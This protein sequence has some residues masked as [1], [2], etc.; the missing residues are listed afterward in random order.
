[1]MTNDER[2]HKDAWTEPGAFEVHS[3]VYRIPLPL[4]NDGLRAVNVYAIAS[5]DSLVL[6]DSG[7][8]LTESRQALESALQILGAELGDVDRFLITH[9]HQDH[10]SQAVALRE[11]FGSPVHIGRGEEPGL[12]AA[13]TPGYLPLTAQ[14][15]LLRACDAEDVV[16]R[17]VEVLRTHNRR[18]N[19][20]M[21]DAW[22]DDNQVID[23]P[24]RTLEVVHTPGHT[25]GHVV[26]RDS[27]H[28][29]LFAGDHIL[30]HI[31]PS[32]GLEPY[33]EEQP[34]SSYLGALRRVRYMPDTMLLP[35]HG[36][37]SPS[38]HVRSDEILVHHD[39]RLSVVMDAVINGMNTASAVSR[40]MTWTR[41]ELEFHDLD[42]MNQML[43]VLEIGA[44]LDL[45]VHQGRLRKRE[46]DGVQLYERVA[47]NTPAKL[48]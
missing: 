37:I 2:R 15:A 36:P 29:L 47:D 25:R 24:S 17:L 21:P 18:L 3:G 44:H 9:L 27:Q 12:T 32:I 43:A 41:R 7:W 14:L 40:R 5:T 10:Y 46:S 19:F 39:S 35:A 42:P 6:V 30:P 48:T 22:L 13:T 28:G 4:P 16:D 20:E 31:T 1:M 38:V 8:A 23:L 11:I 33:P 45:L 34:L 26:F